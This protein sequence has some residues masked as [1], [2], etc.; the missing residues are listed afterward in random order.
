MNWLLALLRL[1]REALSEDSQ[2]SWSR[3]GSATI[4]LAYAYTVVTTRAIP[5][6]TE[7]LAFAL[8][9]LYGVNQLKAFGQW[10]ASDRSRPPYRPPK[11]PNPG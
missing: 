1:L 10:L 9:A 5:E 6:R 4:V 2:G 7:E 3:V 11:L 8:A